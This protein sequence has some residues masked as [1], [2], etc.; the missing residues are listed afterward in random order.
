MGLGR[1]AVN[2]K[3]RDWL[4]SRQHFWGEPFPILHELDKEGKITGRTIALDAS[5]LP[6]DIPKEL[7]FDTSHNSPEP[8]LEQAPHDWLFVTRNGK[9][10]KRETNTMPQW[11]GSCWYYLRF[12]DP[13][14]D[15]ALVDPELEKQ[16]MPVDLYVGGAEHAVLHLLYA[17]FWH[18]VLYDYGIVSQPEPFQKLV[19][20][21]MILGED[22]QKMSKSR[23]NVVNPDDV[24]QQYGADSLRLYEMFMGPLES[25][26]PWSMESVGGVRGFLD[27]VW[28]MI[29][30]ASEETAD[31]RRQTAAEVQDASPTEEQNRMLHK[32]IKAVTE[33]IKNMSFNTA[34]ARMMEFTNFFLKEKVRPKEAMEKF[35]LLLSPFAP[36]IAEEL[37]SILGH[38][39]T[40]AYEPFPTYDAEAIKETTLEI[41]V[42]I[43]GKLRSKIVIAAEADESAMEQI[44][45]T[46]AKIVELLSGKT[47]VKKI[48]VS[49]K[50]VNFVVK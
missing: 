6:L 44:A 49:G 46:D 14:N 20:Q 33:D 29:V 15:K 35:V 50:M 36:H 4:F 25:V 34:I 43:N 26:K 1:Q 28:R 48:I 10:Y 7:K 45:L 8:P 13:K 31:G 18:K 23:G 32:T 19:N 21:G 30:D 24:V 22:G 38:D 12:I 37:W 47:I 40:L 39:K 9:K 11:A 17:R 41:P 2:Y 3:L 5:E 42:S 27:R 16:W